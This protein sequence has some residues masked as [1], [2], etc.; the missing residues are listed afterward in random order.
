[1]AQPFHHTILP[2]APA[3]DRLTE[4][5]WGLRDFEHRFGRPA[6][7]DVAA[8]NG[9]RPADAPAMA[10]A[11]IR[12]TI[13]A[14]WQVLG[15]EPDTRRPYRVELGDGQHLVVALYDE[16]RSGSISFDPSATIDADSFARDRLAAPF[17]GRS[18]T[19]RRAA[20]GVI[21]TDGELY[22]HHQ[23]FRDLFLRRLVQDLPGGSGH[24]FEVAALADALREP[25]GRP[26][27]T[28][29]IAERTS[30]SCHH[31]VLRWSGECPCADGATW[32]APLRAALERLA[33]GIDAAT[34]RLAARLPGHPDPW[35]AR[36]DYVD[37]VI[38]AET[39]PRSA[40]GGW[41]AQAPAAARRFVEMMETQRRRLAMFASDAWFWDDPAR[42]ETKAILR[43]AAWAAR[44][45][46][47]LAGTGL[48]RRLIDDLAIMRTSDGQV[49]GAAIYRQALAEVGQP[50]S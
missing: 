32:K 50:V 5:R 48:E 22:G 27:R 1:M 12:H 33:A 20:A 42:P 24:G 46:D 37:V 39:R 8:R 14:P 45:M 9:G 49:D 6:V 41:W 2:L 38:G 34:E 4:I 10:E 44:R 19:R 13:L 15:S 18:A 25:P 28:I 23:P 17:P 35:A 29:R 36:D 11:G 16:P 7:R 30:W 26:F 31:G 3:R 40:S 47:A 43:T 21:A